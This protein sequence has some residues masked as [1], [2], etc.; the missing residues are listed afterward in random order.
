MNY[1]HEA[2]AAAGEHG[3]TVYRSDI[4]GLRA[5]AVVS[6]VLF[7]IGLGAIPGG[8]VGVDVFF[9]ISGYLITGILYRE[10]DGGHFSLWRFYERRARRILPAATVVILTVLVA[11]YAFLLPGAYVDAA[12]SG[13]AASLSAANLYFFS[14][15]SYFDG[16]G[17]SKPLLHMWSLA[18]EEQFYL[19]FPLL[20]IMLRKFG[21]NAMRAA[22]VVLGVLS[23][24]LACFWVKTEP[25]A[26]FYLPHARAWE[27]IL[28]GLLAVFRWKAPAS[29]WVRNGMA[30]FGLVLI[31]SSLRGLNSASAFPGF[32]AAPA[33]LGA[34]LLLAAASS[35]RGNIVSW[36]MSLPPVRFVGLISYSLYLWHWPVIVFYHEGAAFL[37]F[38]LPTGRMGQV[39]MLVV[40]LALATLSWRFIERPFRKSTAATSRRVVGVASV[41]I[42][43]TCLVA[44]FPWVMNGFPGRFS[45]EGQKIAAFTDYDGATPYRDGKCFISSKFKREDYQPGLCLNRKEGVTN[46]MI[47]GDSHAAHL[48]WGLSHELPGANVGQVTASG[49]RPLLEQSSTSSRNCA[50]LMKYAF[51]EGLQAYRPDVVLIAGLWRPTDDLAAL[52]RTLKAIQAPGRKVILVGPMPQYSAVLPKL[53]L[54]SL[55]KDPSWIQRR[56]LGWVPELDK[57]MRALA[58]QSGASYLSPYD[59]IC[60]RGVCVT[61]LPDG[62]PIQFDTAHLTAAGS[63]YLASA[64][65]RQ[66]PAQ[67]TR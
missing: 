30:L 36:G 52:R 38:E 18:V 23:F 67:L 50:E 7:H 55:S 44:A 42:L 3:T 46:Y 4:D 33:C 13:I 65:L 20:L 14:T 1:A 66:D 41:A 49:C 63:E 51:S 16:G 56:Q 59:A 31:L 47:I 39:A 9:V 32:S 19:V 37:P 27:L 28:G 57:K 24:A 62:S 34:G 58:A 60:E 6:V 61:T 35:E 15:V 25:M 40:S 26:A 45:A 64:W 29:V 43:A 8:F 12:K 5:L 48:W 17:D 53:L 54:V 10:I 21:Q 11:S 2:T 22:L